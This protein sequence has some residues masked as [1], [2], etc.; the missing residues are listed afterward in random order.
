MAALDVR[1]SFKSYRLGLSIHPTFPSRSDY[2]IPPGIGLG[3]NPSK[4]QRLLPAPFPPVHVFPISLPLHNIPF[5]SAVDRCLR[6]GSAAS[7]VLVLTCAGP[8]SAT[9]CC[10]IN[11]LRLS[12]TLTCSLLP[13][14]APLGAARS[15]GLCLGHTSTVHSRSISRLATAWRHQMNTDRSALWRTSQGWEAITRRGRA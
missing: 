14:H 5:P 4:C 6:A 12:T 8:H 15:T 10:P 3:L 9:P 11:P 1:C 7:S 2:R 13:A